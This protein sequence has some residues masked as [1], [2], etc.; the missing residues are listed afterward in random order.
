MI[1]D[2]QKCSETQLKSLLVFPELPLFLDSALQSNQIDFFMK[3]TKMQ[4]K[5]YNNIKICQLIEAVY[6]ANF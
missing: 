1:K 6:F 4:T 3:I 2:T 5:V